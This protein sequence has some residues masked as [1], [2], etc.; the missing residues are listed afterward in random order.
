MIEIEAAAYL[1]KNAHPDEVVE[2]IR[3]VREKGFY[4]NANVMEVIRDNMMGKNPVKPQRSFEVELTGR[5]KED[6]GHSSVKNVPI[7][8]LP[9]NFS[10][11]TARW[12]ATAT[13]CFPN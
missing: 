8:K 11:A 7:K 1:G 4:Y 10:S 9:T 5:E 12:K 3:M 13:T 6:A 2:T